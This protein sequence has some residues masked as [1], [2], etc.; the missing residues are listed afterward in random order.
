MNKNNLAI[1]VDYEILH[2]L[3][4]IHCICHSSTL[5]NIQSLRYG[6]T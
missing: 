2:N 1:L 5:L 3:I 6:A 4:L